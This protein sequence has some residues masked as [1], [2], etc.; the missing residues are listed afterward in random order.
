MNFKLLTKE[1]IREAQ[2]LDT[3]FIT[4][5]ERILW[6]GYITPMEKI[7][8]SKKYEKGLKEKNHEN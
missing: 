6:N 5:E 7:V 8:L 1:D 4:L 3:N 2:L